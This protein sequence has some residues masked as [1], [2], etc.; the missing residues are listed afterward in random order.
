MFEMLVVCCAAGRYCTLLENA[1]I[2]GVYLYDT[3]CVVIS[4][5][6]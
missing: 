1:L 3:V 5:Q 6:L 4:V 2:Y